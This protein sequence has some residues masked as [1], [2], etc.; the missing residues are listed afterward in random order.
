MEDTILPYYAVR[1]VRGKH[2]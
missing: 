2:F 1:N